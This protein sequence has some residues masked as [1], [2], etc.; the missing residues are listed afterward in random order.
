MTAPQLHLTYE[1]GHPLFLFLEGDK[2]KA[3]YHAEV[4][5]SAEGMDAVGIEIISPSK[6]VVYC[7]LD[8]QGSSEEASVVFTNLLWESKTAL[9]FY[10]FCGDVILESC[11]IYL[12]RY[13]KMTTRKTKKMRRDI[14][15][16][17]QKPRTLDRNTS[18]PGDKQGLDALLK[19]MAQN[20]P[21]PSS[22]DPTTSSS[23]VSP[24][25]VGVRHEPAIRKLHDIEALCRSEAYENAGELRTAIL[26][27]ISRD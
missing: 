16:S 24:P 21:Q 7:L 27:I 26:G 9:R 13:Q 23:G 17:Y 2:R 22:F 11:Q 4:T 8:K 14:A 6:K 19:R 10:L 15:G 20:P 1:D 25:H 18:I 5:T 12:E 3:R